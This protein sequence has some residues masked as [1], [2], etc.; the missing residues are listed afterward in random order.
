METLCSLLLGKDGNSGYSFI[1]SVDNRTAE[2]IQIQRECHLCVKI[3]RLNILIFVFK[4][5]VN[6][7]IQQRAVIMPLK[8]IT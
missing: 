1:G 4:N 3:G 7:L 8:E 6:Y 2:E 5:S